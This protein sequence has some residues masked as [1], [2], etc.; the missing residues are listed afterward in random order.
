MSS[1]QG[2]I[3]LYEGFEN[4]VA[5]FFPYSDTSVFYGKYQEIVLK[6]DR[7]KDIPG[8]S[9]FDRI[10]DCKQRMKDT[11]LSKFINIRVQ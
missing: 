11:N 3:C 4:C 6:R 10:T 5:E 8:S 9:K 1:C 7:H 2:G